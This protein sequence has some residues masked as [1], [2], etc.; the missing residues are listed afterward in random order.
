M[1]KYLPI[2][3]NATNLFR[4]NFNIY[5]INSVVR[6]NCLIYGS[7]N[8]YGQTEYSN[9]SVPYDFIIAATRIEDINYY[10]YE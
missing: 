2:N 9:Y 4:Q 8:Q 5:Q 6:G 1:N 3:V 7:L 10:G